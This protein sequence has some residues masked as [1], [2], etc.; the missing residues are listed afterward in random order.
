MSKRSQSSVRELGI[1]VDALAMAV[2]PQKRTLVSVKPS[3]ATVLLLREGSKAWT[4]TSSHNRSR[5]EDQ[6]IGV[7]VQERLHKVVSLLGDILLDFHR[8]GTQH[9]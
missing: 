8:G 1:N 4:L 6:R 7:H 3:V 2:N 5:P 9:Q